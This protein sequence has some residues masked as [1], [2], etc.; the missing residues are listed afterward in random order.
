M[1]HRR[2]IENVK[3]FNVIKSKRKPI[4]ITSS[5]IRGKS[6]STPTPPLKTVLKISKKNKKDPKHTKNDHPSL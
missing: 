4:Y 1:K 2:I 3:A 6:T 5:L